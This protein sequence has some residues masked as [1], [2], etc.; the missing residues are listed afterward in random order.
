[1]AAARAPGRIDVEFSISDFRFWIDGV[2]IPPAILRDL[3]QV[4]RD[5]YALALVTSHGGNLSIRAGHEM[6]ITGTNTMLG[7]LQERH[8]SLVRPDGSYDG[9]PPSSDT[10]LHST[11]YAITGAQAVAHA[12]PRHAIALSFEFDLFVPGDL[13]GQL[14]L[15]E[16]PVVEPGPR[17]TEQIANALQS[18]LVVLLRGHGAYARGQNLWE[19]LHWITALEESA[20]IAWLR[21]R[22]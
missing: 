11:I 19:A 6:W 18:R 21:R 3:Q 12:H 14:H 13:E 4:G 15:K 7:H 5:L 22:P 20:H 16:V 2:T 8:I 17:Q 9:P 1:M 10:V